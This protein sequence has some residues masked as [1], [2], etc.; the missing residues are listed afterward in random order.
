MNGP[1][2][3][4]LLPPEPRYDAAGLPGA[5]LFVAVLLLAGFLLSLRFRP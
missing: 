5:V 2:L 3:A 1:L 4:S